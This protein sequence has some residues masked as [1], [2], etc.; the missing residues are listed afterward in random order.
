MWWP[1]GKVCGPC[2]TVA[3]RTRGICPGCGQDR[4]LP[5]PPTPD[6]GPR[7]GECAGIPHDFHCTRCGTEGESYRRGTCARCALRDD[8]TAM[9]LTDPADPAA[10]ARLVDVLCRADRPESIITWKRSPKVQALLASLA[11]GTT[12]LTHEG[13]DAR[14][15]TDGRTVDHLRALLVHHGLLPYRDPY[16]ARFEAW[17]EDKLRPL[18]PE[19]A[20]PVEQFAKWHHLRRIRST[21][22][23]DATARGPVHSAK[24]EVTETAKFLQWLWDT[25]HRT[26]AACTQQDV[27]EWRASGPTTRK[28]IKTFF[29]FARRTR[30]N[31]A[32]DVGSYTART[33]PTLAQDQRLAWLRELLTGNSESRPYRVAG[34]LLLLYAQPLVRVAALRT[35]AITIDPATGQAAITFAERPIPVP[36]G[37]AELLRDHLEARP[38]LRTGVAESPW[39]FPGTIA[40]Q[41]LHPNGIMDRLRSLGIELASGRNRALDELVTQMPPPLVADALGYSYQVAFL[42]ASAAAEPWARYAGL[43]PHP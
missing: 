39:L 27:D 33:R 43:R 20:K 28:Q 38:N 4:L 7:C 37:F 23:P 29:G 11:A 2:F 42:H 18:A 15:G 3:T 25:H 10:M 22:T 12:P 9:L 1:E 17:I 35:E 8:L 19:V 14:I 5:G 34:I 30:L 40:G 24:Q 26:A 32:V 21:A 13:L 41:H 36:G 31:T 16:L 6:G